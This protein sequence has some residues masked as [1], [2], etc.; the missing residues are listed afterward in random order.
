MT[1]ETLLDR[2]LR[3]ETELA[4]A[5]SD[6]EKQM[7]LLSHWEKIIKNDR[8]QLATT[9]ADNERLRSVAQPF[10]ELAEAYEAQFGKEDTGMLA[11][12]VGLIDPAALRALSKALSLPI[13]LSALNEVRAEVLEEAAQEIE[14][15]P[16]MSGLDCAIYLGKKAAAYRAKKEG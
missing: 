6:S 11:T 4:E 9:R 1:E 16:C 12:A 8:E 15:T 14:T 13:N 5:M 10:A 2:C 7:S 3:L